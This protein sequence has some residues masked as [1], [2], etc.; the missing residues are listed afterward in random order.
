MCIRKY[1]IKTIKADNLVSFI[2]TVWFMMMWDNVL[3]VCINVETV[4][5]WVGKWINLN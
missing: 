2:L 1:I 3:K 5:L 4:Y